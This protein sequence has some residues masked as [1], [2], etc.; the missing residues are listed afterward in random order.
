MTDVTGS[1]N[2]E[3]SADP[4]DY[5][6]PRC[7]AGPRAMCNKVGRRGELT[8]IHV[9]RAERARDART[10]W[11]RATDWQPPPLATVVAGTA[12]NY[13]ALARMLDP[14]ADWEGPVGPLEA[15]YVAAARAARALP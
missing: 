3:P 4:L 11:R 8:G 7:E 1:L 5:V 15:V 12:Q 9:S 14:W 2:E 6:C 13:R 10:A